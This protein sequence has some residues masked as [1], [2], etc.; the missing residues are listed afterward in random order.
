MTGLP[1]GSGRTGQLGNCLGRQR[2]VD[3][4][5]GQGQAMLTQLVRSPATLRRS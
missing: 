4:Q 1:R 2:E 5:S 3:Q